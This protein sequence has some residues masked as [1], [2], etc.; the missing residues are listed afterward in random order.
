MKYKESIQTLT[1]SEGE[2]ASQM[3]KDLGQFLKNCTPGQRTTFS[4][5]CINAIPKANE[6]RKGSLSFLIAL[7][8]VNKEIIIDLM[9]SE[10]PIM[11]EQTIKGLLHQG[12]G[13]LSELKK[14]LEEE[15]LYRIKKWILLTIGNVGTTEAIEIIEKAEVEP[16][17]F[18][19]KEK[20]L[21][22]F[23]E[24]K[25][26]QE[27]LSGKAGTMIIQ[28]VSG[29][30]EHWLEANR[31]KG[32]RIG[33]GFIQ[34]DGEYEFDKFSGS[35]SIFHYGL[36]IGKE[37]EIGRVLKNRFGEKEQYCI[38][39]TNEIQGE[40]E[41]LSRFQA[42]LDLQGWEYNSRSPLTLQMLNEEEAILIIKPLVKENIEHL[43]AS[44]NQ[45]VANVVSLIA[46]NEHGKA[47]I[48]LDPCCGAGTLLC[49]SSTIF[50]KD[51]RFIGIDKDRTAIDKE[52]KNSKEYGIKIETHNK[53]FQEVLLVKAADLILCNPPFDNRVKGEFD[54][55]ELLRF[56]ARNS[57]PN[58]TAA[59]YTVKKEELR[60][61]ITDNG[62]T[63]K[64]EIK[65]RLKKINPSVFIINKN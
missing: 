39:Y 38:N 13:Y 56:I 5:E 59:I 3:M 19:T 25:E 49:E 43:P 30:E 48:I 47:N 6:K 36:I 12:E 57:T 52:K 46:E 10:S 61:A 50:G 27:I 64:E 21:S 14:R 32:T 60:K 45:T 4:A 1:A 16:E 15:R 40:K 2:K 24:Q 17:I 54:H 9:R 29:A 23:K 31:L 26:A 7:A 41:R 44:L 11:R 34:L 63:L 20:I 55:S 51:K 28:T 8:N 62:L 35:R 22:R 65:L 42:E 58:M 53:R 18:S 37:N 33:E